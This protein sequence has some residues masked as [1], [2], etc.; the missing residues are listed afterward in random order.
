MNSSAT[1]TGLRFSAVLL[2]AA[3]LPAMASGLEVP[4][5]GGRVNDLADILSAPAEERISQRLANLE[6]AAGTQVAVLTVPSL[7]GESLEDF[8]LRV[9]ETWALGRADEDDGA[10][11]L[12]A[13][14]DR[15]MRLEV[16]YGLEPILTDAYSRR[17]IDEVLRP[18]FR[19]GDFDGGV[20]RAVETMAALVEGNDI[21]PPPA[22]KPAGGAGF[23][24]PIGGM[25]FFC[26]LVLPFALAA[27][28]T[29]GCSGWLVYLILMPFAFGIPVTLFSPRAGVIALTI[30]VIAVPILRLI[31]PKTALG[32]SLRSGGSRR[33]GWSSSGGWGSSGGGFSGGGFS[34]GGGSFGGGG[35]SGSW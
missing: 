22:V 5:L 31:A 12:I 27:I 34:G 14:D 6:D 35:S 4:F 26:L 19:S 32:R 7:E 1:R 20:E 8:S 11:L 3:V 25:I 17:I 23:G 10:L 29:P 33:G 13:R 9:A 24:L 18:R 30:W 28:T 15:K 16:G 21:L 2:L